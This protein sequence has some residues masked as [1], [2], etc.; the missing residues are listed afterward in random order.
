MSVQ[1]QSIAEFLT[2]YNGNQ[3][4]DLLLMYI[5]GAEYG[6]IEKIAGARYYFV[7][8]LYLFIIS[9]FNVSNY[10]PKNKLEQIQV[11]FQ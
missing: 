9:S 5:E 6:I 4:I 10:Y 1:Y 8:F 11:Q 3:T 2:K 7:S